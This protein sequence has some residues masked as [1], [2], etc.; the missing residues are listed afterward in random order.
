M[1]CCPNCDIKEQNKNREQMRLG[2]KRLRNQECLHNRMLSC[3]NRRFKPAQVGESDTMSSIAP[4]NLTGCITSK[5][6]DMYTIGTSESVL[7]SKYTRYQFDVCSSQF[8]SIED[9]PCI[10]I[11]QTEAMRKSSLGIEYG[12]SCRCKFCKTHRCPCKKAGRSCNTKCHKG[13]ACFNNTTTSTTL[14]QS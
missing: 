12:S 6:Y 7:A 9:I 4:R 10:T 3:S 1:V 8:F 5:E 11:T 14:T 2:I 13:R